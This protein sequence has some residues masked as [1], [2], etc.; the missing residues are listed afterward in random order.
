MVKKA[1]FS[2]A[3]SENSGHSTE[4]QS[5]SPDFQQ[6]F[7]LSR[8]FNLALELNKANLFQLFMAYQQ[9]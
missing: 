6:I 4:L 7:E 5:P 2:D 8:M 3:Q 1:S 9:K